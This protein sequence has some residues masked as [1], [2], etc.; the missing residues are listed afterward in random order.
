MTVADSI[1]GAL[2]RFGRQMTLRRNALGPA[3]QTSPLD[4]IV[5][6]TMKNY[7]PQDLVGSIVQGDS[8]VTFS[9]AEISAR[10]WPGP[11]ISGDKIIIDGNPRNI[12]AVEPKYLSTDILVYVC[13]VSG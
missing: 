2:Q 8:E 12:K 10:Q 9:N 7:S 6:G 1:Y 5:Y 13:Q 4:V 11:P 3:G